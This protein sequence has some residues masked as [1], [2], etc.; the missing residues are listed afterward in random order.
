MKI[1][2]CLNSAKDSGETHSRKGGGECYRLSSVPL[3]PPHQ[4][5]RYVEVLTLSTYNA[6]LFGNRIDTDI[7]I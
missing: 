1:H 4:E 2:D 3:T 7:I 5:K 6:P